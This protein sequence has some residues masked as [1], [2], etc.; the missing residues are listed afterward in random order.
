MALYADELAA[1]PRI[2]VANRRARRGGVADRLAER[3]RGTRS[4]QRAATSS[5]RAP[6]IRSS[7]ASARSRAK[8]RRLKA[9]IATKCTSCAR[10]APLS[11]PTCS[12][13][14]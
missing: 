4:R 7:T 13:S 3:V 12:T 8:R 14:T 10:A 1:R 11:R 2:V 6:S 5:P 9:A